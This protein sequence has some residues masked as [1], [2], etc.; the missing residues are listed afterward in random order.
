MIF[1]VDSTD[2]ERLPLVKSELEKVVNEE[3]LA[4]VPLLI[5]ANK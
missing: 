2:K 5:L 4:N 1:V 3:S